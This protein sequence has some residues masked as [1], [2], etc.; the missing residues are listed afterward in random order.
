[1]IKPSDGLSNAEHL[2]KEDV[3]EITFNTVNKYPLVK[4]IKMYGYHCTTPPAFPPSTTSKK[5]PTHSLSLT[6][7]KPQNNLI[8][9]TTPVFD[10]TTH[11]TT[12]F[13]N[14]FRLN[15]VQTVLLA[16]HG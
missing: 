12:I 6:N 4:N 14:V 10:T 9:N 16:R 13:S 3:I 2:T 5:H 7:H 8:V 11:R 1:M 15:H